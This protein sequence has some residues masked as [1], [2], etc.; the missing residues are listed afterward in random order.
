MTAPDDHALRRDV[1]LT[2]AM[3]FNGARKHEK[4][5]DPRFLYWADRLGLL[6]WEEMPSAYRF[7]PVTIHR[8]TREW[9]DAIERD[10]SH[11]CIIAWVPINE[12]W[13]VPDLPESR[14]QRDF[15]R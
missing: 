12:S 3:G 13:G 5:E 7:D 15:V 10:I 1:E 4:I 8:V 14:A 2:R 11:P 9:M 6:V